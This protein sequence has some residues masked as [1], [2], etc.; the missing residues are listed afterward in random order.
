[1]WER[2]RNPT[3]NERSAKN[4]TMN[5]AP[6]GEKECECWECLCVGRALVRVTSRTFP[7]TAATTA[8]DDAQTFCSRNF[9]GTRLFI[10]LNKGRFS[11][12]S[13]QSAGVFLKMGYESGKFRARRVKDVRYFL[14]LLL[15]SLSSALRNFQFSP[16]LGEYLGGTHFTGFYLR[17]CS[18]HSLTYIIKLY[19]SGT[20]SRV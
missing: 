12:L 9:S 14:F 15:P 5:H 8:A 6:V 16:P 18:N 10:F 2:C 13:P 20:A 1:M 17:Q 3:S 11:T 4:P 19:K 7:A